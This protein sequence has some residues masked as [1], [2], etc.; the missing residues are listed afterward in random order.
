MTD[1]A[2]PLKAPDEKKDYGI[3]WGPAL[4][5]QNDGEE[6]DVLDSS[7]WVISPDGLTVVSH[8]Y[9][10]STGITAIWLTGG[11]LGVDYSCTNHV[12]TVAG[13]HHDKTK[14]LKVRKK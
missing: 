5:A 8:G 12:T 1:A 14:I 11:E 4:A 3:R 9:N 13:R 2:W 7:T 6:P 10:P